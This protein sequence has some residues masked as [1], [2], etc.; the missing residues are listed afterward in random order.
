MPIPPCVAGVATRVAHH[1]GIASNLAPLRV[2]TMAKRFKKAPESF[3]GRF[4][5]VP[6]GV[7]DSNAFQGAGHPARSLLYELIR[8][9][10]GRN[11]GHLQL[12]SAWL[13]KRGWRSADVVQRAKGEL[14]ERGL[15]VLTRQGGLNCGPCLY[16]V[17]WLHISNFVG[18]DLSPQ[19][20]HPG[21]WA[22]LDR[23]PVA[24]K[25][26]L[27]S[28]AR[29]SAVPPNGAAGALAV[30]SDGAK[31][32]YSGVQSV[33]PDGNNVFTNTPPVVAALARGF[34]RRRAVVGATGRSG[35]RV[36]STLP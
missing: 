16:V 20:Y 10:S 21:R 31:T 32:A 1:A 2:I 19:T 15:I 25:R 23:L 6:H 7:M 27:S 18:L 34:A 24:P 4:S 5:A 14:L 29:S 26:R 13:K 22:L 30:P 3:T 35:K 8:Q 17:T 11:N 36:Q 12:A 9:L 33:P 28:V